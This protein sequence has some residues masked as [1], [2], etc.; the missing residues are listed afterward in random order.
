MLLKVKLCNFRNS[1][2]PGVRKHLTLEIL[3][4]STLAKS[5]L[6]KYS[7]NVRDWNFQISVREKH[8]NFF[9]AIVTNPE[10]V[11]QLKIDSIYKPTPLI[12]GTKIDLEPVKFKKDENQ[13]SFGYRKIDAYKLQR[14]L[15]NM[16]E[17]Q[18][19]VNPRHESLT[20]WLNYAEPEIPKPDNN[21]VYGP[22]IYTSNDL[23]SVDKHQKLISD[24]LANRL[25]TT[26]RSLYSGYG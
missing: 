24:K 17:P 4:G 5:L 7:A 26:L 11:W 25:R 22:F 18:K 19:M 2:I 12:L 21:Y 23:T 6:K 9:D 8:D 16:Q 15:L 20:S 13:V 3:E 14:M 10:E 1:H